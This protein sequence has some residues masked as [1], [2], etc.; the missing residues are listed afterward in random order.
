MPEKTKKEKKSNKLHHFLT[1][2]NFKIKMGVDLI[3]F[4]AYIMLSFV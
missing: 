1:D 3:F 4:G 2:D